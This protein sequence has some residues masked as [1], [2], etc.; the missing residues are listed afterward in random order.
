MP[1]QTLKEVQTAVKA[2]TILTKE[3]IDKHTVLPVK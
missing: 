2:R 1:A 3:M